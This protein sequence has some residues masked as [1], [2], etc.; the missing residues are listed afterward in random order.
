M[1]HGDGDH[2]RNL[3]ATERDSKGDVDAVMADCD[4]VIDHVYHTKSLQSGNDGDIPKL[5]RNRPLWKTSYDLIY[6][7]RVPHQTNYRTR[8]WHFQE[9]SPG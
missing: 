2:K 9:Q 3:V 5:C 7:D 6:A 8:T 4:V 1:A